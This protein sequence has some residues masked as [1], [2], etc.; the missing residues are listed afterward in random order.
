MFLH[1]LPPWFLRVLLIDP[2]SF[3]TLC[4]IL[5]RIVYWLWCAVFHSSTLSLFPARTSVTRC[6]HYKHRTSYTVLALTDFGD[7][8]ELLSTYLLIHSN[9]RILPATGSVSIPTSMAHTKDYT[10]S[11]LFLL[12]QSRLD[13]FHQED[14]SRVYAPNMFP[15]EISIHMGRGLLHS[16][17]L[18]N[19]LKSRSYTSGLDPSLYDPELVMPLDLNA[20]QSHSATWR[21]RKAPIHNP[22]STLCLF[23]RIVAW[24]ASRLPS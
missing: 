12:Y 21:C 4:D 17:M 2:L 10:V 7:L 3:V 9:K 11:Q 19:C 23:V 22:P 5:P 6:F 20:P 14:A 8:A 24:I 13:L 16:R 18:P 15:R 1:V